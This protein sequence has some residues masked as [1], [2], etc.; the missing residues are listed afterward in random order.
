MF[1]N[2]S[3]VHLKAAQSMYINFRELLL[4]PMNKEREYIQGQTIKTM[5]FAIH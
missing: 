3:L 5:A 2:E 1:S 4:K